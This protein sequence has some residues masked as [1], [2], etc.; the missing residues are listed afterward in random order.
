[1]ETG[2]RIIVV[3]IML[4]TDLEGVAGVQ[5]WEDWC[6][7]GDRFYDTA[8]RLLTEEV[9]AVVEGFFAAGASYVQVADGHEWGGIDVERLDARVE[10]ARGWPGG[11][12]FNLDSSFDG[13]AWVGQHAK[14]SAPYAHLA[15]TRSFEYLDVSVNGASVGELGLLALCASELGV[16]SFFAAGDLAL[17]EEAEQLAPGIVTCAVKRGVT[18]GSG[19]ECTATEYMRRNTGAIHLPP[20]RA[21]AALRKA[22]EAA[23]FKLRRN[24]PPL[25]ALEKPFERITMLR[26]EEPFQPRKRSHETHADSVVALMNLPLAPEPLKHTE[27]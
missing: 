8:C 24:P 5:A 19:E 20:Q 3:K 4:M 16:P 27:E 7:P 17:A 13:M 9:N 12:P 23:A 22:A 14:A 18:P 25:I 6:V 10:Y 2:R 1:M 21:R 15:H 11:F 26:P